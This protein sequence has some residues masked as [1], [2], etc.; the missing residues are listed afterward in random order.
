MKVNVL[1]QGSQNEKTERANFLGKYCKRLSTRRSLKLHC[2]CI[3]FTLPLKGRASKKDHWGQIGYEHT[4]AA[5][6]FLRII[7]RTTL[8]NRFMVL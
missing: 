6:Q 7:I 8:L 1:P 3:Y 4:T 2:F 5:L